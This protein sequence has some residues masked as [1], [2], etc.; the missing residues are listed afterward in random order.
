MVGIVF[1]G[2]PAD[3][4]RA[5]ATLTGEHLRGRVERVGA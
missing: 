1:E 2:P 3:L 4:V 5:P